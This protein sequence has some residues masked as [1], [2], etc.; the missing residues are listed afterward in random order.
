MSAA[1]DA[2]RLDPIW[3]VA[4]SLLVDEHSDEADRMLLAAILFLIE[5]RYS[6]S[7]IS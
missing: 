6:E 2:A 4:H 5:R 1:Y 3:Q 7:V